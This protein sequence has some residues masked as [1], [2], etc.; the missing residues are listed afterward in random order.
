MRILR[1]R[2]QHHRTDDR[3]DHDGDVDE[4]DRS[5][6]EVLEQVAAGQRADHHPEAGHACPQRDRPRP[7]ALIGEHVGDDRQRGRHDERRPETLYSTEQDQRVRRIDL[8]ARQRPG[9]EDD[10]A[11]NEAAPSTQ[12]IT[13]VAGDQQETREHD[14]VRVDDPLQLTRRGLELTHQGRQRDVDDRSVDADDHQRETQHTEHDPAT[15]IERV[16]TCGWL[17]I[18]VD[19]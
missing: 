12:A 8:R 9:P 5:P 19:R 7:L 6:P 15:R 14:R 13:R 16:R 1:L 18:E 10:Q 2:H 3:Q 17:R 11:E 4:K